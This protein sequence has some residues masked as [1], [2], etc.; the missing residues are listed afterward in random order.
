MGMGDWQDVFQF[1]SEDRNRQYVSTNLA[2]GICSMTEK[3]RRR[4]AERWERLALDLKERR[5]EIVHAHSKYKITKVVEEEPY[6][7]VFYYVWMTWRLKQ[8]IHEYEQAWVEQRLCLLKNDSG[9]LV[10]EDELVEKEGVGL[11]NHPMPLDA[12]YEIRNPNE[13]RS[14]YDRQKAVEYAERWWNDYNPKF[15]EFEVD[16][17]NYVSQCL[18]AGGAPMKHSSDRAKGWWYRFEEPVN[19]SF[20]WAVAHALRWY[21]PTSRSGLRGKEVSS[22]DQL[23]LG[24]VIC[25][26]FDGDGRWQHNTIVVAKDEAGM[27]L[28]NAHTSNSRQRYWSYKDSYAWTEKTAYKFFRIQDDF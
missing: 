15:Q 2:E 17:T 10:V 3:I 20:S 9:W 6:I 28:V 22:A 1:Y 13:R 14:R 8:T 19:W 26:D 12:S 27:P 4:E 23:E 11:L 5:V 18:W 25:Y 21:L 16:C 7:K 24:D